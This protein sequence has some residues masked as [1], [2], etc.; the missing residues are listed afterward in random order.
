MSIWLSVAVF[1]V[2]MSGIF[3][4]VMWLTF[5]PLHPF[6]GLLVPISSPVV[7]VAAATPS[8]RDRCASSE[9]NTCDFSRNLSNDSSA[10]RRAADTWRR[11]Q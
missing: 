9:C 6:S 4:V 2:A 3:A 8:P 11:W 1:V 10:T 5:P 7:R